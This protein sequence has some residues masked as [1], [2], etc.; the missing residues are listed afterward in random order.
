MILA[1]RWFTAELIFRSL[2]MGLPVLTMSK[3]GAEAQKSLQ[4]ISARFL[5]VYPQQVFRNVN[6]VAGG[7][8]FV[9]SVL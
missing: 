1:S 5:Y 8:H 9:D 2:E 7:V 3:T 6:V 4:T